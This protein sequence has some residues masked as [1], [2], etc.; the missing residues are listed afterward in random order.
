[1][2]TDRQCDSGG[3]TMRGIRW[4]VYG[5]SWSVLATWV[6]SAEIRPLDDAKLPVT[7]HIAVDRLEVRSGPGKEYYVTQVLRHGTA[8]EIY[9]RGPGG[10]L[11]IRPPE[12][13]FSWVAARHVR[14]TADP[15]V[16]SVLTEGVVAWVGAQGAQIAQH[17]WQVRLRRGELLHVI[18]KQAIAIGPGFAIE[19]YYKVAP[20]AGEFRWIDKIQTDTA[21]QSPAK[22]VST[23]VALTDFQPSA[24]SRQKSPSLQ[25]PAWTAIAKPNE[26][27]TTHPLASNEVTDELDRLSVEL[28]TLVSQPIENWSLVKLR[29]RIA[30]VSQAASGSRQVSAARELERRV[31]DFEQLQQRYRAMLERDYSTARDQQ[32]GVSAAPHLHDTAGDSTHHMV[33]DYQVDPVAAFEPDSSNGFDAEGWLVPVHSTKRIAPPFA[34]IDD[35]GRVRSYVSPLP[36]LNLRRYERK[37]VGL[38]GQRRYVKSLHAPHV[39]AERVVKQQQRRED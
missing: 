34:V 9:R 32:P 37:Y 19:T 5:F 26:A 36:G 7:A 33:A 23:A 1:M 20:P 4:L 16:V 10:W 24:S 29:R 21:P 11:A 38:Y 8:V 2:R 13:S 3:M 12:N 28:S 31:R 30:R 14:S 6:V 17:K 22:S 15:K 25:S 27:T 35:D 18:G 39:T